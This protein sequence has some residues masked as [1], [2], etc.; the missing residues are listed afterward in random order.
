MSDH[1]AG[2]TFPSLDEAL[3]KDGTAMLMI[4]SEAVLSTV[5]APRD[6][7]IS[8]RLIGSKTPQPCEVGARPRDC[9]SSDKPGI[10][11]KGNCVSC[12]EARMNS[13]RVL[14]RETRPSFS[15]NAVT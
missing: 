1:N 3:R 4:N 6:S 9:V 12:V 2:V 8:S 15:L 7:M 11:G 13:S 14:F 10:Q 5:S